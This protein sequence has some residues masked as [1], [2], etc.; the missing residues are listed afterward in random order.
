MRQ[1]VSAG[2]AQKT[3]RVK[4]AFTGHLFRMS[5]IPV[6]VGSGSVTTIKIIMMSIA[7]H[8]KTLGTL[9]LSAITI[10]MRIK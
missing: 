4:L 7:A 6:P 5:S 2:L 1:I 10:L 9:A 3:E 8:Q